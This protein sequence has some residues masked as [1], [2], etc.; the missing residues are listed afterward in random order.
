MFGRKGQG[1]M[2]Y[3]MTYGW[4]I[5]VVMIVGIVMWQLG[6]FNPGGTQGMTF[7]G[8]GAVKPQLAG[9]GLSADGTFT[10]TFLNAGGAP[11]DITELKVVVSDPTGA[12]NTVGWTVGS[13]P[14]NA[15][16]H[17]AISVTGLGQTPNGKA[18]DPFTA[19]V[20]LEYVVEI[21]STTVTKKSSGTIRGP[22]E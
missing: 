1:A 22:L 2:E 14:A 3:L 4:A 11:I 17:V 20:E 12:S 5:L 21:G 10:G 13:K 9:T 19:E 7:K 15:N 6:I 16:E 18:G 8:F